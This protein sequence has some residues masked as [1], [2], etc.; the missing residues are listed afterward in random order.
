MNDLDP[1]AVARARALAAERHANQQYGDLPYTAHLD[2]VAR[3]VEEYGDRARVVAYLH[4]IVEDTE[5]SLEEVEDGFGARVAACVDLVT[6]RPGRN[7]RERKARTLVR[8][9]AAPDR[10]HL[11]LVV[12]AADRLANLRA[13]VAR[14]R[15]DLLRMYR[16]EHDDF[17]AAVQRPGLCDPLW[18]EMAGIIATDVDR[19]G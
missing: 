1:G 19:N 8:L 12:K 16:R 18:E 6:D 2:D 11:A 15:A 4:D 9:A 7:R 10:H 5:T 3:L 13:C 14:E 17:Q